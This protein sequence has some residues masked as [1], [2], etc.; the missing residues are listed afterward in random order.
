MAF[1]IPHDAIDNRQVDAE[2]VLTRLPRLARHACGNDHQ[3]RPVQ[4]VSLG[5]AVNPGVGTRLDCRLPHVQRLAL[6]QLTLHIHQ[7]QLPAQLFPGDDLRRRL[8]DHAG[9]HDC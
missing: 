9:T 2:H 5:T 1:D 3:L 7:H 4:H 6:G 8:A